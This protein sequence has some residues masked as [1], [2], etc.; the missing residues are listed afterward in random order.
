MHSTE[1]STAHQETGRFQRGALII[2]IVF[3]IGMLVFGIPALAGNPQAYAGQK[4]YTNSFTVV[5][6]TQKQLHDILTKGMESYEAGRMMFWMYHRIPNERGEPS[7]TQRRIG[8]AIF[9]ERIAIYHGV[10]V[11][12]N[13]ERALTLVRIREAN[14]IEYFIILLGEIET[15]KKL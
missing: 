2:L 9:L 8:Y 15:Q 11:A 14:Q 4:F 10:K 12:E 13:K 5:C 1:K 3:V 7:C 6:D